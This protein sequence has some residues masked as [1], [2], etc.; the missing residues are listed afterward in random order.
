[1]LGLSLSLYSK[2]LTCEIKSEIDK[3]YILKRP[4]DIKAAI[5]VNHDLISHK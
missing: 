4:N 3:L 5:T 2:E 1:M